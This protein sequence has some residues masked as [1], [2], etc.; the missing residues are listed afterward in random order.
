VADGSVSRPP[1]IAVRRRVIAAT[2]EPANLSVAEAAHG[3]VDLVP[4]LRGK[5]DR[6][7]GAQPRRAVMSGRGQRSI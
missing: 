1:T 6:P 7:T 3:I 5:R 4:T 2:R